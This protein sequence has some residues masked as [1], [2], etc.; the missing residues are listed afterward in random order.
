MWWLLG[1]GGGGGLLSGAAE[2]GAVNVQP[3]PSVPYVLYETRFDGNALPAGWVERG[4]WTVQDGLRPPAQ[5]GYDCYAV[6]QKETSLEHTLLEATVRFDDPQTCLGLVRQDLTSPRRGFPVAGTLALLDGIAGRIRFCSAWDG[7]HQ[8]LDLSSEPLPFV[9]QR[10]HDYQL[11][12]W[13]T[14]VGHQAFAVLDLASGQR[15]V[16]TALRTYSQ[17]PGRQTD[18]PG[19]LL[20][21]GAAIVKRM[22][23]STV[24]SPTPRLLVF[25][26]SCAEGDAIKPYF[27][28]R[29]PTLVAD[30]L[31]GDCAIAAHSGESTATVLSQL[32]L[33]LDRFA[34]A[35]VLLPFARMDPDFLSWET[36]IRRLI[37]RVEDRGAIPILATSIPLVSREK[38]AAAITDWVR[39][40][41]YP[42]VDFARALGQPH[43]RTR[44]EP[45]LVHSDLIH[46]NR[47]G[48]HAVADQFLQ[49]VPRL[50]DAPA[51]KCRQLRIVGTSARAG[52]VVH[53]PVELNAL[54]NEWFVQFSIEFDPAALAFISAS[55]AATLPAGTTFLQLINSASLGRVGFRLQCPPERAISAGALALV[56]VTFQSVGPSPFAQ[57]SV[58]LDD[59]PAATLIAPLAVETHASAT[60]TLRG[61]QEAFARW[62]LE[63]TGREVSD[64]ALD[65]E[66]LGVTRVPGRVGEGLAFDGA[67]ARVEV[68]AAP[69]PTSLNQLTLAAWAKPS[70]VTGTHYLLAGECAAAKGLFLRLRDG[71]LE[72]GTWSDGR[73][74]TASVVVGDGA[75][76]WSHFAAVHSGWG[77]RL[78]RDG[79]ELGEL[80]GP[81]PALEGNVG[82]TLGA[83][84]DGT[85]GLVGLLSDVRLYDRALEPAEIASLSA[86]AEASHPSERTVLDDA[87]P[88]GS[89]TNE[90][91]GEGWLWAASEPVPVSGSL[92]HR[93]LPHTG[94]AQH[95]FRRT[96]HGWPVGPGETL[97]AHVYL[98]RGFPARMIALQW[99][100]EATSWEHRAYWGDALWPYG[101][102]APV[103]RRYMGRLPAPGQ[104]TRLEVPAA[105]VGLEGRAITGM[106][107]VLYDGAA[108]WDLAGIASPAPAGPASVL[109]GPVL[110]PGGQVQLSV[111]THPAFAT[112]VLGSSDLLHWTRLTTLAFPF[113]GGVFVDDP[114]AGPPVRFYRLEQEPR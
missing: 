40:S 71:A 61:R 32:E 1:V 81:L 57:T 89:L 21:S 41:G 84:R 83:R 59:R 69:A 65:G 107:F 8:P 2:V 46:P 95:Y 77:W 99:L 92:A 5:G 26:D 36:G 17:N 35:F 73:E 33:D 79:A 48:N 112:H 37:A 96:D 109:G 28:D 6:W 86:G 56:T 94:L 66:L 50:F 23:F 101:E 54:G 91:G 31:H 106:S 43:D 108:A 13:K 9:L 18:A 39:A 111:P 53:L 3:G 49:D 64:P 25:G 45:T 75:G 20:V 10:D 102:E 12:L 98:D 80:A 30:L 74:Q 29:Y 44:W 15:A 22:A 24:Y 70:S 90:Y 11:C 114:S 110:L 19:F 113:A 67:G 42:Y 52:T 7:T 85:G 103:N 4:G 100:D 68:P 87:L 51:A 55:P 14:D 60:V 105:W 16:V 76:A 82:W 34:P 27:D 72:A 88:A 97:Y 104:W 38:H 47:K 63:G 78:Y 58:R 93:T 62:P